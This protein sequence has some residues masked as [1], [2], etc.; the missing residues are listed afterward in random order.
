M[1][2]EN[3]GE[4]LNEIQ[5]IHERIDMTVEKLTAAMIADLLP[6]EQREARRWVR[7][8]FERYTQRASRV[9][10]LARYE[11]ARLGSMTIETEHFLLGLT[12][13]E[14]NLAKLLLRNHS[15]IET[16]WKEVERR[17]TIR[18]KVSSSIDLP[19]SNECKRILAYAAEESERLN[20]RHIG[21]EHLLL[22]TLRE[23]K[24]VAAEILHARGFRLNVMREELA[25][26]PM[27][28][29]PPVTLEE[30]MRTLSSLEPNSDLVPDAETAMRIAE[31]LWIPQYGADTVA[32]QAPLQAELKFNVWIVTGTSSAE[33]PLF[34]FIHQA[35][36]QIL[37]IG[38][39]TKQ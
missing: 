15:S 23:E 16:I 34:A 38:G 28:T 7:R 26:A 3:Y 36:G 37:D 33:A 4:P 18:E 9:I 19:L 12:R 20:H 11:A 8:M 32:R 31:A 6:E 24:C 27:P 25:R 1:S 35:D 5:E 14:G 2:N 39:P 10:T 29:E 22:G 21:T 17:T 13:D 30:D